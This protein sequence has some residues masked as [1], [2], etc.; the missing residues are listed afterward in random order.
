MLGTWVGAQPGFA[1]AIW[2][3]AQLAV[4]TSAAELVLMVPTAIYANHRFP[5]LKLLM[6]FM[7]SLPI[8]VPPVVLVLG[9]LTVAPEALKATPFLAVSLA[10]VGA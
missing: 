8:V 2:L 1:P 3:L 4:V 7:T 10:C 6:D 5:N 9:V